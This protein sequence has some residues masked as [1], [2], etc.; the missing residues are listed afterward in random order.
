M[1]TATTSPLICLTA[2]GIL[3]HQ[4]QVLL[5]KHKK[6]SIWLNPGGHLE[7]N[8]LPHQA[9]EREFREETG[10]QVRAIDLHPLVVDDDSQYLP[11]PILTNLHWISRENYQHRTQGKKRSERTAKDW[12]RGCEQHVSF[13]YLVAPL[14]GVDFQQNVAETDG[15]GWFSQSQV[16]ELTDCNDNV[17]T[18]IDYAFQLVANQMVQ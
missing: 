15:I 10:I 13:V 12:G 8:E 7:A 17:R 14:S 4:D 5:V 3:I 11:S 1:T 18:E 2:A 6:L 9:A 16:H